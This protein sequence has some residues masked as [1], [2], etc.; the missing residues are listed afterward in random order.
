MRQPSPPHT[1]PF[2]T[3]WAAAS[4]NNFAG[5]CLPQKSSSSQSAGAGFSIDPPRI[6]LRGGEEQELTDLGRQGHG[7]QRAFVISILEY[8]A[9]TEST[10]DSLKKPTPFLAI[11]EPEA[12]DQHPPRARHFFRTL[13]TISDS[14]SAQVCY[15]T[16]SPYF[17]SPERFDASSH[18]P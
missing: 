5:T 8:L 3:T 16:H 17:V 2:S 15:A 11:E 12:S 18:F 10:E 7:F 4:Q 1:A 9:D 13:S 14:P 6:D